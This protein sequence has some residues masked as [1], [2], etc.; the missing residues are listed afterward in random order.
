M[1]SDNEFQKGDESE[2]YPSTAGALK[3]GMIMLIKDKVC[4]VELITTSKTGKHGH[5]KANITARDIFTGLKAEDSV[6]TGHNVTMVNVTKTE[7]DVTMLEDDG[8]LTLLAI[9]NE[10]EDPKIDLAV[11]VSSDLFKEM[12]ADFDADKDIIVSVTK[13]MGREKVM[14]YR[15]EKDD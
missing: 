12:K 9:E 7:Y 6:P 8:Q 2:T 11:D 14:S 1:S 5:A 13:A 4:K 10:D 3:K 15:V